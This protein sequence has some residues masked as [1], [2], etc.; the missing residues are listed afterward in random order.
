M[1]VKTPAEIAVLREGG[2]RLAKILQAVAAAAQPGV[3]TS[4]LDELS[5]ALIRESG[6]APAFLNYASER[7]KPYPAALC[8]SVN[9]E[10]VHGLPGRRK[11][12]EGDVVSLDLGLRHEGL[13]TDMATTIILGEVSAEVKNLVATTRESLQAGLAAVRGGAKLGDIGAAVAAVAKRENLAIVR[14]LGGHGVGYAVHE[15]PLIPNYGQPGSGPTLAPGMVLAIEPMLAFG[16]GKVKLASD[17]F[18]F[19][20]RDGEIAAHFEATVAVTPS[21]VEILTPLI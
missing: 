10:V 15:P 17:G 7:G 6:D 8:V 20:T 16:S 18:T 9:E 4:E 19:I 1:M 3:R 21:G 12:A 5:R 13:Y 2:K 14:E 11:L